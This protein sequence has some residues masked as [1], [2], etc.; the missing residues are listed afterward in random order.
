VGGTEAILTVFHQGRFMKTIYVVAAAILLAACSTHRVRCKGSLQPINKP[1][2]TAGDS[3][4]V[5]EES[6]P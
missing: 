6:R 4:V 1:A 3:K 5:S 2:A